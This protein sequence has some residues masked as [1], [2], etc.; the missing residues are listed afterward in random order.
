M[1]FYQPVFVIGAARSGTTLLRD[2][3]AGHPSVDPVP[4]DINYIWRMGNESL[5]HDELSPDDLSPAKIRRV[6]G[7][8][9]RYHFGAP[10]LVEKTVSNCLRV[11]FVM[12]MYPEGKYIHLVRNGN[13]VIESAYRQWIAP[14][15][16]RYIIQKA[17]T[18]PLTGAFGY[19][20][21]YAWGLLR[22][23][24]SRSKTG[25]VTWGPRYRGIDE[26]LVDKSI[27][28]VCAI[29]WDRCVQ[30]A[31]S[32]LS[33]LPSGKVMTIVY[34]ELVQKPFTNMIHIAKFLDID[35][36]PFSSVVGRTTISRERVGA[37]EQGLE[38]EQLAVLQ[39]Y[40]ENSMRLLNY[41]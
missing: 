11:P 18:Y 33:Y 3:I 16:W 17:L 20:S 38:Q 12:A 6:K 30:A 26:D 28:E 25:G 27:L 21:S 10:Y 37:A 41:A 14:A 2:L 40:I 29:Q 13:D 36:A 19:A 23:K 5:K 34:E 31:S 24:V 22:K 4:Y 35:P 1:N 32:D 15:D 39:P 8:I 7:Q 9:E